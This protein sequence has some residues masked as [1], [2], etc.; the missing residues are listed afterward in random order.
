MFIHNRSDFTDQDSEFKA[1][2]D[3]VFFPKLSM[4]EFNK[5]DAH[6]QEDVLEYLD[7]KVDMILIEILT[8]TKILKEIKSDSGK[9]E[10]LDYRA[11]TL[12]K[13]VL[14]LLN[15]IPVVPLKSTFQERYTYNI[16]DDKP[17]IKA[18]LDNLH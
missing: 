2:I 8:I 11:N 9:A 18:Q 17:S 10:V 6:R 14:R 3:R 5:A 15:Q 13:L 7:S 12:T 4:G 1:N 16:D